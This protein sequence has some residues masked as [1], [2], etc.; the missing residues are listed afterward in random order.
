MT[1][2]AVQLNKYLVKKNTTAGSYTDK[3]IY[4][5][6]ANY[7]SLLTNDNWFLIFKITAP[8]GSI[9]YKNSGW[10]ANTYNTDDMYGDYDN[11]LYVTTMT[12]N[13]P[14]DGDGNIIFGNYTVQ[15]KL[16]YTPPLGSPSF[17]TYSWTYDYEYVSPV[18]TPEITF[19]VLAALITSRDITAYATGVGLVRSHTLT[20]PAGIQPTE[21][22][23]ITTTGATIIAGAYTGEFTSVIISDLTYTI[24]DYWFII[25][26][27]TGIDKASAVVGQSMCAI[28]CGIWNLNQKYINY[29]IAGRLT[30][31]ADAFY[32]LTRIAQ[33]MELFNLSQTCGE[34]QNASDCVENIMTVGEFT[35]ECSCSGDAPVPIVPLVPGTG[36]TV[37]VDEGTGITVNI[38][39]GG[40]STTY[41]VSITDGGVDTTQIADDAVT[42]AK[43]TDLNVTT[44]KIN[45][46]G[47]TTG[48]I[49]LLAVDTAQINAQAVTA[50]KIKNGDV[51]STQ[52]GTN[53]VTTIKITDANV[54]PP[55]VT[56]DMNTVILAVEINLA[57]TG[58]INIPVF[59][60]GWEIKQA[61]WVTKIVGAGGQIT[62]SIPSL[63]A[64]GA[65]TGVIVYGGG[66]VYTQVASGIWTVNNTGFPFSGGANTGINGVIA[67][68]GAGTG[69]LFIKLLRK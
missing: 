25:D 9:I 44:E 28:Y 59:M 54:T 36:T 31:A 46:L 56:A 49:A 34:P 15:A 61:V 33:L 7:L 16:K 42:T 50:A 3:T 32:K 20:F 5:D 55:K 21:P 69:T 65:P 12:K 48:K 66:A 52:L 10:D 68:G 60:D 58:T 30:D 38:S 29:L 57:A 14:L 19:N 6:F 47:V 64:L 63:G 17:A 23:P 51:G 45:D 2:P 11:D 24:A 37:I 13:L 67:G 22:S 40:S 53:S 26:S 8:D 4:L 18:I 41:T 1:N 39:T 43:I 35:D 62:L 27:C